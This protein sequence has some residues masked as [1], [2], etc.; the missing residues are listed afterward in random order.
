MCIKIFGKTFLLPTTSALTL[1]PRP[2]AY[3]RDQYTDHSQSI[4]VEIGRMGVKGIPVAANDPPATPARQEWFDWGR[5]VQRTLESALPTFTCVRPVNHIQIPTTTTKIRCLA[6][7]DSSDGVS[8]NTNQTQFDVG[9]P[10]TWLW[11]GAPQRAL[12][13]RIALSHMFVSSY[14]SPTILTLEL[15]LSTLGALNDGHPGKGQ[16]CHTNEGTGT[17]QYREHEENAR[18]DGIIEIKEANVVLEA[19]HEEGGVLLQI[20]RLLLANSEEYR[21]TAQM[22]SLE[23]NFGRGR[24]KHV[25]GPL[26]KVGVDFGNGVGGTG[27]VPLFGYRIHE[28]A[29]GCR[30]GRGRDGGG[31]VVAFG[32][33][34]VLA[35]FSINCYGGWRCAFLALGE[36]ER[37]AGVGETSK[38]KAQ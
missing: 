38:P 7:L 28:A 5:P 32:H 30:G 15:H 24:R 34:G 20:E 18:H 36:G 29:Q 11:S 16:Q 26:G 19:G 23:L 8:L 37:G 13:T 22:F 4:S 12:P 9:G 14:F 33:V 2:D 25:L 27:C 31:F 6:R 17:D 1:E 10:T 21:G 3:A 35:C